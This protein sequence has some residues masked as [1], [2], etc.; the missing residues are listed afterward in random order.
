MQATWTS[1]RA[2]LLVALLA[3]ICVTS[4][5]ARREVV[6]EW[7]QRRQQFVEALERAGLLTDSALRA[8]LQRV[9]REDLLP[10]AFRQR[11]YE[12]T[13][14]QLPGLIYEPSPLVHVS[15]IQAGKVRRGSNVLD[16]EPGAGYRAALCAAM[17]ATVCC[18][19][20][21]PDQEVML[22]G[23]LTKIGFPRIAV[24]T[25]QA[26]AGWPPMGPYN[27][28]FASWRPGHVPETII[29]QIRNQGRLVLLPRPARDR[30]EVLKCQKTTLERVETISIA[31]LA[32]AFSAALLT[33]TQP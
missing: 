28:L 13:P 4:G 12:D 30:I 22:R 20:G 5:C 31:S 7:E 6:S 15:M 26:S 11:A 21:S 32:Q 3:T 25:A 23:A 27:V 18:V 16:L 2:A 9:P 10:D 14:L 33:V 24:H 1:C 29:D 8:A 17:G 19:V